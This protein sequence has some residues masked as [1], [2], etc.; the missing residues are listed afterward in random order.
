MKQII[1]QDIISKHLISNDKIQWKYDTGHFRNCKEYSIKNA[2]SEINIGSFWFD[3]F[4]SKDRQGFCVYIIVRAYR[5][6]KPKKYQVDKIRLDGVENIST[7]IVYNMLIKWIGDYKNKIVSEINKL[8]DELMKVIVSQNYRQIG[9][10]LSN[11][12]MSA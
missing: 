10:I 9:L 12:I 4:C 3:M 8:D 2:K 11:E 6:G 5:E 1:Q 7:D